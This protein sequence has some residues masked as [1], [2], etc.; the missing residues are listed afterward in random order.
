M[1]EREHETICTH[2]WDGV[3]EKKPVCYFYVGQQVS[4]PQSE[5]AAQSWIQLGG[6][7]NRGCKYFGCL[8]LKVHFVKCFVTTLKEAIF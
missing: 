3:P 5:D 8:I 7:W 1:A 2:H 6:G 4:I